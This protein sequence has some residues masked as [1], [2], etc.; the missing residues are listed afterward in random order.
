MN[1]FGHAAVARLRQPEAPFV[2]GAM[3]PDLINMARIGRLG[4]TSREV[5]DGV[6][7]HH[8][9]DALF[10]DTQAFGQCSREALA[11]L[12]SCGVSRGPA[13]AGAHVGVEMLIDS[14]LAQSGDALRCYLASLEWAAGSNASEL[15]TPPSDAQKLRAL[16][17]LLIARGPRALE[18]S[19]KRMV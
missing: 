17:E 7:F 14:C 5:G 8:Q 6:L 4:R 16:A 12:R 13:R 11:R 10:H 2:F 18:T 3:L 19:R 15:G 1:F 9:T